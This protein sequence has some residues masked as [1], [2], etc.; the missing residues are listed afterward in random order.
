MTDDAT[1]VATRRRNRRLTLALGVLA[2]ALVGCGGLVW[3]V[4]RMPAG[5]GPAVPVAPDAGAVVATSAVASALRKLGVEATISPEPIPLARLTFAGTKTVD[6]VLTEAEVTAL[7]RQYP[8]EF[9]RSV[10]IPEVT[11]LANGDTAIRGKVDYQGSTYD[12]Y[13]EMRLEASAGRLVSRR[14]SAMRVSGMSVPKKYREQAAG[15]VLGYL[16][17]RFD[18]VPQA[19][20]RELHVTE[21]RVRLVGTVPMEVRD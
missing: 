14:V 9:A 3:S 19:S 13:V 5:R 6:V 7:L 2:A 21:G 16:N 15:Q 1:E 4:T 17:A 11:F 20:V 8:P 12:A 18:Q 10:R